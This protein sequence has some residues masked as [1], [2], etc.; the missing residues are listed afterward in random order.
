MKN[1][2][3]TLLTIVSL[4]IGFVVGA[5]VIARY[6]SR[7]SNYD[8]VSWDVDRVLHLVW[9]TEGKTTDVIDLNMK[10]VENSIT[11]IDYHAEYPGTEK[12]ASLMADWLG[13]VYANSG[14][15]MPEHVSQ[16]I[17]KHKIK[18]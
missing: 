14:R 3:Y 18:K 11:K 7:V 5:I 10:V 8:M 16:W 15:S 12:E 4:L 1:L 9:L 17:D 2:K 6:T 13:K